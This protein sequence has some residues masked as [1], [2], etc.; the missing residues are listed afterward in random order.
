[1]QPNGLCFIQR[2]AMDTFVTSFTIGFGLSLV[3]R[4]RRLIRDR[5]KAILEQIAAGNGPM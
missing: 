1:M 5:I 3:W 2:A 4:Y